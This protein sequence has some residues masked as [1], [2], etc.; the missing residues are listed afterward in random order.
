MT[1]RED[2]E[3][4]IDF[5]DPHR[6]RRSPKPHSGDGPQHLLITLLGDYW[7]ARDE[8][9][10]SAALVELLGEFGS[11][12]NAARQ[13]MRRLTQRGGLAQSKQ[14][15]MTYYGIPPEIVA[16]QRLRLARAVTFGA[17]FLD[18]DGQWTVVSYSIPESERDVRRL[19]R[20]GLRTMAFGDLQDGVW[21]SPHDRR[22]D[23]VELLDELGVAS[24]H[25]MRATWELRAGDR[26]AIADAFDLPGLAERYRGFIAEYGAQ[27]AWAGGDVAPVEALRV[28]TKL[29]NDWL[30]FRLLDPE[31][32]AV[33][34]A[35]DWPRREARETFLALYGLLG[36]AAASHVRQTIARYDE[37]LSRIVTHHQAPKA[38]GRVTPEMA[39]AVQDDRRRELA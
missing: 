35:D 38:T 32:P 22:A 7:F 11:G 20:N 34:L 8:M 33:L 30:S 25:V 28:R 39:R 10:P 19:L 1:T 18:W 14:G 12:E 31:L 4:D 17:D 16:S 26:D 27:I 13:A 15:R 29:T 37:S 3:Q 5:A 21:I 24:G 2:R 9:L 6:R 36:P 23:A